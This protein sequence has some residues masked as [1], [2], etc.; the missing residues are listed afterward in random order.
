MRDNRLG[1][2]RSETN[3]EKQ[4]DAPGV[5]RPLKGWRELRGECPAELVPGNPLGLGGI[6]AGKSLVPYQYLLLSTGL[7]RGNLEGGS[8]G[9]ERRRGGPQDAQYQYRYRQEGQKSRCNGLAA[10]TQSGNLLDAHPRSSMAEKWGRGGKKK[11]REKKKGKKGKKEGLG[12]TQPAING[13]IPLPL[14]T[15]LAFL[16]PLLGPSHHFFF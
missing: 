5:G 13:Q 16:P 4:E 8:R 1:G 15:N 11:K 14:P 2:E 6:P 7:A 9:G 10:S 3:L 12:K